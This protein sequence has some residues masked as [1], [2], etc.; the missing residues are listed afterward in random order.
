[1][2]FVQRNK[3][4][5]NF[6]V[7]CSPF[8]RWW[9]WFHIDATLIACEDANRTLLKTALFMLI[10]R[11]ISIGGRCARAYDL[12]VNNVIQ[13]CAPHTVISSSTFFFWKSLKVDTYGALYNVSFRIGKATASEKCVYVY[14]VTDMQKK[15][16]IQNKKENIIEDFGA[17]S[18]SS[19][20]SISTTENT[21]VCA[22]GAKA[23]TRNVKPTICYRYINSF[24][25]CFSQKLFLCDSFTFFLVNY[26]HM[27]K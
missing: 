8:S 17:L 16:Q 2:W 19:S 26:F 24:P 6:F 11:A 12:M 25:F 27:A 14:F 20:S 22:N 4:I 15:I 3:N 23:S 18:S 21:C 10:M 5:F 1:M 7:I 13:S 9:F